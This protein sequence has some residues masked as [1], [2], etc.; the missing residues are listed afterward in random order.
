M[1]SPRK[2]S[3]KS[4]KPVNFLDALAHTTLGNNKSKK[5][6]KSK[7]QT[8]DRKDP[9]VAPVGL[10][11]RNYEGEEP[12]PKEASVATS[13][14]PAKA[15]FAKD[16]VTEAVGPFKSAP[17]PEGSKPRVSSNAIFAKEY[18]TRA[19]GPF[20]SAPT[21]DNLNPAGKHHEAGSHR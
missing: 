9:E 6:K 4:H 7:S 19:V 20:K 10:F 15:I 14:V 17:R 3:G 13:V 8:P 16:Y 5:S 12:P 1:S 11:A 2:K 18:V 21:P